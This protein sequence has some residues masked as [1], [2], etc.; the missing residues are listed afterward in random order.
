MASLSNRSIHGLR[1]LDRTAR[2]WALVHH[3]II[4]TAGPEWRKETY[5]QV[6]GAH[7]QASHLAKWHARPEYQGRAS[8]MHGELHLLFLTSYLR[9]SLPVTPTAWKYFHQEESTA[10]ILLLAHSLLLPVC[11]RNTSYPVAGPLR[12]GPLKVRYKRFCHDFWGRSREIRFQKLDQEYRIFLPIEKGVLRSNRGTS[13]VFSSGMSNYTAAAS[14][15][16]T[17]RTL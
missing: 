6:V 17:L 13:E 8:R 15:E 10:V 7:L 9:T 3:T 5:K 12:T 4:I 2:G 16:S 11:L 1:S 14:D